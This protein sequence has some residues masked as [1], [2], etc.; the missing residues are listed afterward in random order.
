[1]RVSTAFNR[2]LR[3]DAATV[4]AV[5]IEGT[6]IIAAVRPKARFARCPCGNLCR[7]RYDRS[8][9]RWRHLDLAGAKLFIE[10]QIRRVRCPRCRRVV[11]EQLPWARPAAR[12]TRDL[13]DLICW[14]A[15]RMDKTAVA[16]LVRC[17]WETIDRVLAL[18]LQDGVDSSR[19]DGLFAIGVD[20]VSY[21]RHHGY[22]TVVVDHQ[23]GRVVWVGE[24][25]RAATLQGFF[26]ELGPQR[27]AQIKAVSRDMGDSYRSAI[28]RAAPEA[29]QCIDPFHV[30]K[31]ANEALD[32]LRK[33]SWNRTGR[34]GRRDG[35]KLRFALLKDPATLSDEQARL[36]VTY[37]AD[38]DA[39]GRAWRL[40]EEL[41]GLYQLADPEDA[42]AYFDRWC[43]RA[44]D[45]QVP[46]MVELARRLRVHRD[47]IVA[48]VELGLS[49]GR[50]EGMNSKIRL[51]SHRGY[52]FHSA[53]ALITLIYLCC[54]VMVAHLPHV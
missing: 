32:D 6:A 46:Q 44:T 51:I 54:G 39:L 27:T 49:N 41:R 33:Q 11:S 30:I 31:F 35:A 22:L 34:V 50:L 7:G 47:G 29:R 25:R 14:L 21:R 53:A 20:E 24:G 13:E 16:R 52:G 10:A 17:S 5:R 15:Q 9:R 40:K 28:D 26:A 1:M 37:A 45:S 48:A 8:V 23:S 3:L 4:T 18:R 36:L 38:N 12:L 19:L 42:A 43:Q 2:I